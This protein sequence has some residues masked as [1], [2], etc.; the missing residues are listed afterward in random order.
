MRKDAE[1]SERE[2]EKKRTRR[3]RSGKKAFLTRT[4]RKGAPHLIPLT[5]IE[6]H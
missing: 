4:W 6:L 5:A 3:K 2:R 1:E